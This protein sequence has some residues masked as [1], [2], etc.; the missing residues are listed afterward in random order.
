MGCANNVFE[1]DFLVIERIQ[2]V[3]IVI[4]LLRC[5]NLFTYILFFIMLIF[6]FALMGKLLSFYLLREKKRKKN[7]RR[8]SYIISSNKLRNQ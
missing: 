5:L 1:I 6:D 8:P 7:R 2:R 4:I 3:I